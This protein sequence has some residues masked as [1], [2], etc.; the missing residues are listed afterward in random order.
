MFNYPK[1]PVSLLIIFLVAS[2]KP[3]YAATYELENMKVGSIIVNEFILENIEFTK[4]I[5]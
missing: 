5:I 4:K 3:S 2:I 1:L